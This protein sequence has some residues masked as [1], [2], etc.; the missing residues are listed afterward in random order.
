M[1]IF[2]ESHTRVAHIPSQTHTHKHAHTWQLSVTISHELCW[3]G[4][5]QKC[6]KNCT[7][8]EVLIVKTQ[9]HKYAFRIELTTH[10]LTLIC[11][12]DPCKRRLITTIS[13]PTCRGWADL[14]V[15]DPDGT[16]YSGGSQECCCR[17]RIACSLSPLV[18]VGGFLKNILPTSWRNYNRPIKTKLNKTKLPPRWS[19]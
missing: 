18:P 5:T 8:E 14:F 15:L 19:S 3:P 12:Y 2:K 9:K 1:A 10:T 17:S 4:T 7:K 11:I 6:F 16:A 13:P